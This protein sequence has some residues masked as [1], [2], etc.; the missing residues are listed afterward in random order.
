[1]Q[2]TIIDSVRIFDGESTTGHG[3]VEF[4]D[5]VI[6]RVTTG[7]APGPPA[8]AQVVDGTG[9]TLLPGLIDAHTHVFG[10][11]DNLRLALAF[12]VTTELDMFMGPP[13]AT[14]ALCDL[15]RDRDDLADMRSAGLLASAQG[16]YP[17]NAIPT[18]PTVAG[19]EEADAFVAARQAEGAHFI[20]IMVD[21][22]ANHGPALPAL[23]PATVTALVDAARRRGLLTVAHACALWSA[24][25]A[26]D[27]GVDFLTH[28]PLEAALD[29]AFAD[30]AAAGGRAVIPTLAM[31]EVST[32]HE[33]PGTGVARSL[34]GDPRIAAFLP[35]D[36]R[37]AIAT[38]CE[39]LCV[40]HPLPEHHFE[41][42]L[43][44]VARLHRAGVPL[45]AGTDANQMPQHACPIV[46]GAG[47]H[48]E[49][50]LLVAAGLSPAQ[51]LAAATSVP[52]A[53]FGLDDRG[54]IAPGRRA[55]LL[56]VSGDPTTDITATR[57]IEAIWRGGVRFD[58][59]AHR[60]HTASPAAP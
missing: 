58:R 1:M 26:L 4:A 55:D 24:Q 8:S 52:A 20:K 16:G 9:M 36:V 10:V 29:Q 13:E 35:D 41:Y 60:A 50:A 25:L 11:P 38:G 30:R 3:S 49:L 59:E 12:G 2:P 27:S 28:L 18:L 5:G 19:P 43:S 54:L 56:L 21:D 34:A 40:E 57:S 44:S 32:S 23:G 7:P 42:A 47:L 48:A 15:A 14:R 53:H 46:H 37:D 22:G 31:L 6:T 39:G 33:S 51:A 45:L 17:G